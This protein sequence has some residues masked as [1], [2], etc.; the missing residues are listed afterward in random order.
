MAIGHIWL[1]GRG[2]RSKIAERVSGRYPSDCNEYRSTFDAK[3]RKRQKG[4]FSST[5]TS[6][7][8]FQCIEQ[9]TPLRA[10]LTFASKV[11][12]APAVDD[13]FQPPSPYFQDVVKFVMK[14]LE[15]SEC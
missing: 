12:N 1:Y 14:I 10:R 5:S 8:N 2:L 4:V 13:N 15:I 7:F 3:M 9:R 6:T 11:H